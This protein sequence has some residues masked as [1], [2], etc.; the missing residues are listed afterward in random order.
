MP[1]GLSRVAGLGGS[2]L[3]G[4]MALALC[5]SPLEPP[6]GSR[7]ARCP[8]TSRRS[9]RP[10]AGTADAARARGNPGGVCRGPRR[11]SDPSLDLFFIYWGS[12]CIAHTV[13]SW[14]FEGDQYL[15]I[16]IETRKESGEAYSALRGVLPPVR[17]HLRGRGRAGRRAPPHEGPGRRCLP[18]P[19]QGVCRRRR[20]I[21]LRYLDVVNELREH[22]QWYNAVTHN[23]T[24]TI[25]ALAAPYERR[26]W[27]SW[28]LLLNGYL[29]E[30]GYEN[31]SL[32]CSLPF[33]VLK[34][35]EP[36]Q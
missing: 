25:Q 9:C 13:M 5:F 29:D 36:H 24:T 15:A 7:G 21:L 18:L 28:K 32:D 17:A 10:R 6:P 22:P 27:W 3:V 20:G 8:R 1:R 4:W 12:P 16:S 34:G 31:G 30:L 35:V 14:G 11:V 26:S 2:A 23:R 33:P 19:A